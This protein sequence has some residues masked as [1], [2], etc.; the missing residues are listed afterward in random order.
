MF[1]S[2]RFVGP[3]QPV[4]VSIPPSQLEGLVASPDAER[5]EEDK[6]DQPRDSASSRS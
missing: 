2:L 5:A 4:R 3:Q 6:R 1:V